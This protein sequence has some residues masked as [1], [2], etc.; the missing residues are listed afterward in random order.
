[1]FWPFTIFRRIIRA[2]ATREE[3]ERIV[4]DLVKRALIKRFPK[5]R[6]FYVKMTEG[7]DKLRDK[8]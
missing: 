6:T 2:P 4:A 5:G 8:H 7:L 3:G 1:M